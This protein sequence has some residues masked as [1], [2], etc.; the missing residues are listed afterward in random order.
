M[1]TSKLSQHK[2]CFPPELHVLNSEAVQ[3]PITF[4]RFAKE[5][6]FHC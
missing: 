1:G 5:F 2:G 4:A 6:G 3:L